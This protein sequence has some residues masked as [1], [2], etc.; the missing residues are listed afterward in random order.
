MPDY[1]YDRVCPKCGQLMDVEQSQNDQDTPVETYKCECGFS[2]LIMGELPTGY[3]N[4]SDLVG[5]L[6]VFLALLLLVA[7]AINHW[8]E[9]IAWFP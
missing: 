3:H 4:Q 6:I 1:Q 8:Q 9:I 5:Y 2:L 7:Y